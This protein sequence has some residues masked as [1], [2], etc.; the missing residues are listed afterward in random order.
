MKLYIHIILAM[1]LINCNC[2]LLNKYEE[3]FSYAVSRYPIINEIQWEIDYQNSVEWDAEH[4]NIEAIGKKNDTICGITFT[5]FP[6][7]KDT[8]VSIIEYRELYSKN[9]YQYFTSFDSTFVPI[10]KYKYEENKP[11]SL[12]FLFGKN[13]FLEGGTY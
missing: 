9:S 10:Y 7:A 13:K 8:I 2:N 5:I 3:L 6:R 4:Y 12:I 11:D 1:A